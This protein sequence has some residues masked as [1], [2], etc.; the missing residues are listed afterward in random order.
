MKYTAA[1]DF[2]NSKNRFVSFL[3]FEKRFMYSGRYKL[4]S[5]LKYSRPPTNPGYA[6]VP[7]S[8]P[9]SA[10]SMRSNIPGT[11]QTPLIPNEPPQP[12]VIGDT[13]ELEHVIGYTG[14]YP[15]TLL[16]HPTIP[17]NIVYRYK[18]K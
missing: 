2:N 18:N 12:I 1:C 7:G 13:L 8:V 9:Q 10:H 16:Y 14:H 11:P 15:H 17:N 3:I 5:Y 4:L 6:S